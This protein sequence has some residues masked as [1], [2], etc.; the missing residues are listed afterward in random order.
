MRH[1]NVDTRYT[2]GLIG[3]LGLAY[4]SIYLIC[5]WRET[6][7]WARIGLSFAILFWFLGDYVWHG[8]WAAARAC[9]PMTFAF[10]YRLLKERQFT[11]KFAG[12]NLFALH[13]LIRFLPF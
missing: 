12:G 5:R 6:D 10:N 1:G 13:G 3:T 4:Q 2:F 8:Y 11:L 7:P 9:L